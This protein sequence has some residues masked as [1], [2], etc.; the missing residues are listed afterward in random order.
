MSAFV[1]TLIV[2]GGI[3]YFS[4][5]LLSDGNLFGILPLIGMVI[6][7]RIYSNPKYK[8]YHTFK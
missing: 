7:L 4:I 8:K 5:L 1:A 6:A 3:F 2:C